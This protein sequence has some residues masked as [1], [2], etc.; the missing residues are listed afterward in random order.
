MEPRD[1][2]IALLT[3]FRAAYEAI[4]WHR[5][6]LLG[7]DGLLARCATDEIR[8]VAR[9]TQIYADAARRVHPPGRAP[10]RGRPQ[11]VA[12]PAVGGRPDRYAAL[13]PYE[14]ADLWAGDVPL[15][16]ARPGSHDLW[17]ADGSRV[18]QFLASTGLA[19]VEAKI[20]A[21]SEIDQHRQQWLISACLATRPEPVV[22]TSTTSRPAL[23]AAEA[24]PE[25]LLA[26]AT[27]IADEIMAQVLGRSGGEANWL[28][29]ELLDDHHWAVMPMGAGLS[30]G[31]TGTALFLAQIGALTGAQKYSE[32]ARD[33][34]RPIPLLLEALAAAPRGCTDRRART[35]RARRNQ[36]RP[37]PARLPA[38]RPGHH[39]V[40]R[41]LAGTRRAAHTRL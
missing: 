32:L 3:G 19:A 11:P 37:Q 6:E 17:A 4:A 20:T 23:G 8:Y 7:P 25:Q 16:T 30:N 5:R 36:L 27:D 1:H 13:V 34:I 33:A 41:C 28:S 22:H 26:A 24:D 35:P 18:P 9:P 12:R 31:F 39:Q 10:G 29:L 40:A 15:F 14:L 21:M 38:G 2:E